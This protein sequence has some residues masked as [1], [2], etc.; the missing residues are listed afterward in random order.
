[1]S[2]DVDESCNILDALCESDRIIRNVCAE[3]M[4]WTRQGTM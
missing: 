4:L 2:G 3:E 1:M